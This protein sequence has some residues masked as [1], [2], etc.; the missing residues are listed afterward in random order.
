VSLP[1]MALSGFLFVIT[2]MVLARP[3]ADDAGNPTSGA[4]DSN[5]GTAVPV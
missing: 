4:D 5:V 3:T 1:F 2:M